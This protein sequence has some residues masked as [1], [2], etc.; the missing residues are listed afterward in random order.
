[1]K[2]LLILLALIG[3]LGGCTTQQSSTPS[4]PSKTEKQYYQDQMDKIIK[5]KPKSIGDIGVG[6]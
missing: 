5:E 2:K 4:I 3:S 1:M 6:F